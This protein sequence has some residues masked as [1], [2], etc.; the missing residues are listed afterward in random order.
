MKK[1]IDKQGRLFGKISIIDVFVVLIVLILGAALY[2]KFGVLDI[3]S[4]STGSTPI[5]Y[6]VTTFGIREA[7]VNDLAVGDL[8]F[9]A[10]NNIGTSIGKITA[11]DIVPATEAVRLTDGTYVMGTVQDRFDVTLTL[12]ASGMINNG[13]YYVNKVYEVNANSVRT[14][15][16]KYA[17]FTATVMGVS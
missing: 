5:T 7:T 15:Y 12:E 8:L 1:I 17:E 11:I 6:S 16:T 3:T 4:Q 10:D 14:F 2:V 13:K 9:D